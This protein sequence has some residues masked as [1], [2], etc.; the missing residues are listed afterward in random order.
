MRTPCR[1]AVVP[2]A[3]LAWTGGARAPDEDPHITP[4]RKRKS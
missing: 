1:G 4:Q 3:M 2:L